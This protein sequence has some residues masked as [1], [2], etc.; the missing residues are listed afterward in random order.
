MKCEACNGTG[1][2]AIKGKDCF[3]CDGAGEK[4]DGCGEA[5]DEVGQNICNDCQNEPET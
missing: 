4:C 2:S 1:D 3:V 5:V